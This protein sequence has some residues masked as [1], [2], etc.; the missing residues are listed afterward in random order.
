MQIAPVPAATDV[1]LQ[2]QILGEK[3][4]LASGTSYVRLVPLAFKLSQSTRYVQR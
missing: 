4:R 3:L 1:S 2:T